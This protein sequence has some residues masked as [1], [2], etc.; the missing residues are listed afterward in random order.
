MKDQPG[1]DM[2]RRSVLLTGGS[3][4]VG[5]VLTGCVV[6]QAAPPAAPNPAPAGQPSSGGQPSSAPASEGPAGGG[7]AALTSADKVPAGGGVVLADQKVVVTRDGSGAPHA[8]SAVCTHQGCLVTSVEGG[9]INCRCHGS[10]F[11]VSSG[12]P[13]GGPAKKPLPP[14]AVEERN[15]AIFQA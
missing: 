9:T 7:A 5:V 6:E 12:E 8:F 11:D 15:G 2:S 3:L 1:N 10:K 4:A 14:I 13:V